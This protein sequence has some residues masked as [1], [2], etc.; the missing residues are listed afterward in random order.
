M[1]E[2][3]APIVASFDANPEMNKCL[4]DLPGVWAL[5]PTDAEGEELFVTDTIRAFLRAAYGSG[6]TDALKADA[7]CPV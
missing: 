6:Y 2:P 4:G 1:I 5:A 3:A 7:S